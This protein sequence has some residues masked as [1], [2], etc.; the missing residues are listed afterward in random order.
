MSVLNVFHV[1]LYMLYN[2][3]IQQFILI[4]LYTMKMSSGIVNDIFIILANLNT[5]HKP[6]YLNIAA[7]SL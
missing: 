2:N 1:V 7:R 6:P 5:K 3:M 4:I